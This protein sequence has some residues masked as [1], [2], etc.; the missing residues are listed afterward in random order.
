MVEEENEGNRTTEI[1]MHNS[2]DDNTG[3]VP[4]EPAARSALRP[5][6]Q[7]EALPHPS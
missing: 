2:D 4:P 6:P 3:R 7:N 5:C 1:Y